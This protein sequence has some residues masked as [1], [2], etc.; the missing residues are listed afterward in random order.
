MKS[1]IIEAL[2]NGKHKSGEQLP[3]VRQMMRVFDASSGTVQRALKDLSS[4]GILHSIP[5]KGTFWGPRPTL[6]NLSTLAVSPLETLRQQFLKDW[7]SG[8]F[9][10]DKDLPSLKELKTRY[11]VSKTLLRNLLLQEQAAGTLERVG[12]SRFFFKSPLISESKTEVLLITRCNPW[13][14]FFPESERELDFIRLIYRTA[15]ARRLKLRLLGYNESSGRWIDRHGVRTKVDTH[16]N[17]I[18]IIVSTLLIQKPL[19]LL[20]ALASLSLP[21]SIWWEHPENALPK[22]FL[23]Q[24]EWAFFNSTFGTMPGIIVGRFLTEKGHQQVTYISPFHSSSWSK[25]R[26]KGLQTGELTIS[27]ILDS[28]MASP[29]DYRE[30]ARKRVPKH[31][32]ELTAKS[33]LRQKLKL[34]IKNAPKTDAWVCVNDEVAA[35]LIELSNAKE[36]SASPY[37]LGFDNSAESYLLQFDS[38]DFNTEALA[39]QMFYHI[40][41]RQSE[42]FSAK[43]FRD[44]LGHV[45]EK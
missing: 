6:T 15:A 27:S 12:R 42:P 22:T 5:S 33:L 4:Q 40:S 26:L 8:F 2:L 21:T 25:D 45:V 19:R 14:E 13:G 17:A 3:S 10:P 18:G 29:W 43:R 35:I 23:K 36:I 9:L 32:V 31:A 37:I 28:K 44:V 7:R 20:S 11:H 1:S 38:F 41:A 39:L 30:L 16:K 24:K 34:M